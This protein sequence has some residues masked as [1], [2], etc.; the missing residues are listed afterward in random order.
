[1]RNLCRWM[2]V[3]NIHDLVTSLLSDNVYMM[4]CYHHAQQPIHLDPDLYERVTLSTEFLRPYASEALVAP[5][6]ARRC[7]DGRRIRRRF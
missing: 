3:G 6:E 5:R 4:I 7:P 1:M 2:V